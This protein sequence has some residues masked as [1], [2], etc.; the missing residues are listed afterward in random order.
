M[1]NIPNVRGA[2]FGSR[3]YSSLS[4]PSLQVFPTALFVF[5]LLAAA[6]RLWLIFFFLNGSWRDR[7][8]VMWSWRATAAS[9]IPDWKIKSKNISTVLK[10]ILVYSVLSIFCKH[11]F[12]VT[13]EQWVTLQKGTLLMSALRPLTGD[14]LGFVS[15]MSTESYF[16]TART[17]IS[18][19]LQVQPTPLQ[20]IIVHSWCSTKPLENWENW[21]ALLIILPC[22]LQLAIT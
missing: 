3:T 9:A 8:R 7:E 12:Y 17:C 6:G 13:N 2:G 10:R 5:L 4:S 16:K 22:F 20:I 21:K 1:Q 15:Q 18:M 11:K 19:C 14:C